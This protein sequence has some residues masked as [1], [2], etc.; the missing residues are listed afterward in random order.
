MNPL[1]KRINGLFIVFDVVAG[2]KQRGV[3]NHR[4]IGKIDHVQALFDAV[5]IEGHVDQRG[6][7]FAGSDFIDEIQEIYRRCRRSRPC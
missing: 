5:K 6:D 7:G 3:V 4:T 2:R 1:M